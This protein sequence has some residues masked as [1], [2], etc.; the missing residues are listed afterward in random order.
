MQNAVSVCF[1]DLLRD[2]RQ[3]HRWVPDCSSARALA[4]RAMPSDSKQSARVK[5]V[6]DFVTTQHGSGPFRAFNFELYAVSLT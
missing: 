2:Q 6:E 1:V 5:P 3:S 4:T